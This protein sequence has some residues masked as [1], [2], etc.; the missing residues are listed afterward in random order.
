MM[1]CNA[2]WTVGVKAEMLYEDAPKPQKQLDYCFENAIPYTLWLG[3][4]EI[5]EAVRV[6][7]VPLHCVG[8]A[9]INRCCDMRIHFSRHF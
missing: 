9:G 3:E 7:H 1:L 5:K 4:D 8:D 6:D 2:L